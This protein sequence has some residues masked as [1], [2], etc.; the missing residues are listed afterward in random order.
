MRYTVLIVLLA[1]NT[2]YLKAQSL[3]DCEVVVQETVNAINS[4]SPNVLRQHL[5]SNFEC[6]G[7][8]GEIAQVILKQII[9]RLND[10]VFKFEK[11][12]EKLDNSGLTLVYNFN[13]SK[14]GKRTTTF[15]F[16]EEN[17]IK[18]L[19]LFTV[20]VKTPDKELKLDKPL[21][22]ILTIPFELTEDNLIVVS[23]YI[24]GEK[25]NFI[26]DSGTSS[27]Y[28]NSRYFDSGNKNKSVVGSSKGVNGDID[29]QDIMT[30]ESFDLCG[31][32]TNNIKVIMS[33]L[34]HL[35]NGMEIRGLIGYAIL[36]DYDLLFDYQNRNLLLI[37]PEYTETYLSENRFKFNEVA[38][39]T[40]GNHMSHIPHIKALIGNTVLVFG[41]DC[42]AGGNLIDSQLRETLQCDLKDIE[43]TTLIGID[44]D[45]EKVVHNG[46]IKR[47][48]I[49]RNIFR[50][51]NTVF[52]DITHL[53][54]NA[55]EKI[56]GLLGY[57][58]LS[59][60]K[61]ILSYKNKK[62]I[63]IK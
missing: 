30:V 42:G 47:L 2:F 32:K 33:D 13:Y 61:T 29:G 27:L 54:Q 17:K 37:D 56:D 44:N 16:D 3:T 38:F 60:Q 55:E 50:D 9:T 4:H 10:T 53:N 41:I 24:N 49:G 57:E 36:K 26:I 22:K 45:N 15:V 39:E 63:F 12:E 1:I 31:I 23:A 7:H 8:K 34:S 25:S 28:L 43:S 19:D 5:S 59:K 18:R 6:S 35:E 11:T 20:L 52:S 48:K 51:T 46:T 21:S 58:I 62:I 14:L 40:K